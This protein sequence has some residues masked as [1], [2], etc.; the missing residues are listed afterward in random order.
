MTE[1]PSSSMPWA[2]QS[3]D[4]VSASAPARTGPAQRLIASGR[5]YATSGSV[6][7]RASDTCQRRE[8]LVGAALGWVGAECR[9]EIAPMLSGAGQ[10]IPARRRKQD[11]QAIDMGVADRRAALALAAARR[12]RVLSLPRT[13][14]GTATWLKRIV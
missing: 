14:V 6:R 5:G 11:D 13:R 10:R 7:A 12:A 9:G 2:S 4:S 8:M 3:W 1:L